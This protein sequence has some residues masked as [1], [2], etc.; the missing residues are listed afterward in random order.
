MSI[1]LAHHHHTPTRTPSC[2]YLVLHHPPRLL[3][4]PRSFSYLSCFSEIRS[5]RLLSV[6]CLSLTTRCVATTSPSPHHHL[7]PPFTRH[8][9]SFSRFLFFFP[10]PPS[11]SHSCLRRVWGP[12]HSTPIDGVCSAL[13]GL[14]LLGFHFQEKQE[15]GPPGHVCLLH[16]MHGLVVGAACAVSPC[17]LILVTE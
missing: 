5:F 4:L 10:F 13:G 15:N 8:S 14:P 11:P 6:S 12:T 3:F 7:T 9:R 1:L 17:S 2:L 16:M